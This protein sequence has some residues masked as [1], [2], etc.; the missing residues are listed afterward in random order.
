MGHLN[1]DSM[2][3]LQGQVDGIKED[4]SKS[5]KEMCQTCIEAVAATTQSDQNSS[6]T[7]FTAGSQ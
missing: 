2:K 5:S 4:L 3:H 6:E 1:I 7:S